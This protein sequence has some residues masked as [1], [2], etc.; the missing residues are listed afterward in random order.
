MVKIKHHH[1]KKILVVVLAAVAVGLG[2]LLYKQKLGGQSPEISD[3]N[4]NRPQASAV[5]PAWTPKPG[6]E[7][8]YLFSIKMDSP[9]DEKMKHYQFAI[10]IAKEAEYLNITDCK[11]NPL[12]WKVK[13]GT[14][15]KLKNGGSTEATITMDDKHIYSVAAKS[16]KSIKADFGMGEGL[17]GYGCNNSPTPVGMIL[18]TH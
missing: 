16:T 13:N 14:M 12:V 7:E 17:Y 2:A 8:E 11:S 15:V 1:L 9:E 10:S 3:L 4:G 6:S 18:V 5:G